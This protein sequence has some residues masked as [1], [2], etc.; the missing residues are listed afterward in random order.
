MEP[1]EQQLPPDRQQLLCDNTNRRV[2]KM[3]MAASLLPVRVCVCVCMWFLSLQRNYQTNEI[4][5]G[6]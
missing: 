1:T 3:L 5:A 2:Y 4:M 6:I